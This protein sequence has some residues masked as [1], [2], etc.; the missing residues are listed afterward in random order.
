MMVFNMM[1]IQNCLNSIAWS[2][3]DYGA[4]SW[5]TKGFLRIN[6]VKHMVM[7][8]FMGIGTM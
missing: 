6:A 1:Y 2:V 8:F 5:N 3:I 7:T 4:S